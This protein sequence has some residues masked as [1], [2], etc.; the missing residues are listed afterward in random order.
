MVCGAESGEWIMGKVG[1]IY[2]TRVSNYM[3]STLIQHV[4]HL[5]LWLNHPFDVQTFS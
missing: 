3:K 2:L 4:S 1:V 5:L